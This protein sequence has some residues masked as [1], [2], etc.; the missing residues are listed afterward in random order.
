MITAFVSALSCD[1]VFFHTEGEG[2][3]N[4]SDVDESSRPNQPE[5]LFNILS[6][7]VAAYSS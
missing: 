5:Y 6:A 1:G 4:V 2:I 7:K 3:V